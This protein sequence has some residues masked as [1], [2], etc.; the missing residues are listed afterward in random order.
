M[1]QK[2]LLCHKQIKIEFQSSALYFSNNFFEHQFYQTKI[3]VYLS[4]KQVIYLS[5]YLV[6]FQKYIKHLIGITLV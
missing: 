5:N 1:L 3:L 2:V 4:N 6:Y